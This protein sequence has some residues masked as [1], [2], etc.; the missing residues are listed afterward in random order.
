MKNQIITSI[1]ITSLFW[2][3]GCYI[4]L[5]LIKSECVDCHIIIEENNKQYQDKLDSLVLFKDSLEKEI[6]LS[7]YKTD[8]LNLV[9]YN[10]NKELNKL[11][12]K[13]DE[14]INVINSMSNDELAKFLTDRYK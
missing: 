5:D 11:R 7:N 13:Y 9:I 8:S 1:L 14:T 10:R 2:L 6:N 12:K 4:Y 3:M